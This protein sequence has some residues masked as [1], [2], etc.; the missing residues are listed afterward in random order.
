MKQAGGKRS[1]TSEGLLALFRIE[2]VI[3]VVA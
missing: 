2:R 1:Q 3:E